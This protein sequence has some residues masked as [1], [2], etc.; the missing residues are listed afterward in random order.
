V[1]T[2]PGAAPRRGRAAGGQCEETL[3]ECPPYNPPPTPVQPAPRRLL[4]HPLADRGHDVYETPDVAVH[5]LLAVERLPRRLWEPACGPGA[6]VRVLRAAGHDVVASDLVDYGCPDSRAGIN[7]LTET[8]APP[9][10]GAIVTNAPFRHAAA[11]VAKGLALCPVVIMLLRLSFLES[12]RRGPILDT[13]T[14]ARVH[15]FANRLPMMHRH[16]WTGPRATSSVAH[17]WYVFDRRHTGPITLTRVTWKV[18]HFNGG[19]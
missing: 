8:R 17:A 15:V 4:R 14:L 19:R 18:D 3:G 12:V 2:H 1:I 16:G 6:I 9:D 5:A 11:F 13:G 10:V 7:F